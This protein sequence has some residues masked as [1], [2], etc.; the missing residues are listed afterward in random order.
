MKLHRAALA[1]LFLSA[2][3]ALAEVT[4][5]SVPRSMNFEIRLK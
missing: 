5:Q 2:P 4:Y 3:S 1:A